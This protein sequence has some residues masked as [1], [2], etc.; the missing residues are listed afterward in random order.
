MLTEIA[1]SG[2]ADHLRGLK[3][4]VIMGRLVPTGTLSITAKSRA[5]ARMWWK[6]RR[7][8]RGTTGRGGRYTPAATRKAPAKNRW[9]E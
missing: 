2:R 1:I 8:P 7:Q 3:E 9:L 4:N 5:R 6:R